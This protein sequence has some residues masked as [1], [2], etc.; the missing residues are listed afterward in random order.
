MEGVE[1]AFGAVL[2]CTCR[3]AFGDRL[4]MW[5][6]QGRLV[7]ADGF[8]GFCNSAMLGSESQHAAA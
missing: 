2:V 3:E 4:E 7:V 1:E 8:C 6:P 5:R